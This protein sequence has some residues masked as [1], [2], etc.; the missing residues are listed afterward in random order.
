VTELSENGNCVEGGGSSKVS[1]EAR[2]R[3]VEEHK[4]LA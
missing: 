1:V 3:G 2:R 4:A